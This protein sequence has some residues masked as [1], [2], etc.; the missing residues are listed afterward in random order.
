M[1]LKK[2]AH[3]AVGFA[4]FGLVAGALMFFLA[5]HIEGLIGAERLRILQILIVVMTVIYGFRLAAL[6]LWALG[7]K[8]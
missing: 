5:P 7:R 3:Q 2:H 6:F 8:D 4:A 1:M